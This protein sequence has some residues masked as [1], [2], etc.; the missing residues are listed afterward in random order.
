MVT[1]RPVSAGDELFISY[2]EDYW[3]DVR[4][5]ARVGQAPGGNVYVTSSNESTPANM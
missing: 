2:G 5:C 3:D 1:A 4:R